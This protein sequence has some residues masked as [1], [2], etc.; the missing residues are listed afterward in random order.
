MKEY[1]P[2]FKKQEVRTETIDIKPLLEKIIK[3]NGKLL[4]ELSKR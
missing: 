1:E 3:Y 2:I 4:Q